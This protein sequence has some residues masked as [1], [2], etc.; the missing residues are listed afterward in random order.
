MWGPPVSGQAAMRRTRIG[1]PGWHFCCWGRST[2]PSRRPPPQRAPQGLRRRR[3]ADACPA[4]RLARQGRRLPRGGIH[5]P[6]HPV[7][8]ARAESGCHLSSQASRA[9][10]RHRDS[11]RLTPDHLISHSS[12]NLHCLPGSLTGVLLHLMP[13]SVVFG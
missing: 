13:W 8:G 6:H 7:H 4:R 10:G 2:L 11:L 5:R 9:P 12:S 3:R 1:C